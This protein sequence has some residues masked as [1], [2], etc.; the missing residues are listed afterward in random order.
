MLASRWEDMTDSPLPTAFHTG[1]TVREEEPFD[2]PPD[3]GG[4]TWKRV[5]WDGAPCAGKLIWSRGGAPK[6]KDAFFALVGKACVRWSK[7][8]HPYVLQL[9]GMYRYPAED[10]PVL[11]AELMGSDLASLLRTRDKDSLPLG[12]KARLLEQALLGLAHL[13]SHSP[14]LV[15]GS[16]SASKVVV[17]T[18]RWVGKLSECCLRED[19][20]TSV[21]GTVALFH[22]KEEET[23]Y[24]A[25]EAYNEVF[26][27]E[28]DVFG[29]GVLVLHT[30][31]HSLPL[32]APY[33][34]QGEDDVKMF[35]EFEARRHCLEFFSYSEIEQFQ[36][37]IQRCLRY[38]PEDRMNMKTLLSEVQS[39]RKSIVQE[40]EDTPIPQQKQ[41]TQNSDVE[42]LQNE[43][44]IAVHRAISAENQGRKWQKEAAQAKEGTEKAILAMNE[45]KVVMLSAELESAQREEEAR[46]ELKYLLERVEELEKDKASLTAAKEEL[47]GMLREQD[48][49]VSWIECYVV[50][51]ILHFVSAYYGGEKHVHVFC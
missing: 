47:L 51:V 38:S 30:I 37:I 26:T 2:A 48:G 7:L 4:F 28:G 19:G 6:D 8:R 14:P 49:Y 34:Q 32:P 22:S 42:R 17:D 43:L 35:S 24:L 20:S 11:V 36:K 12:V 31:G 45:E 15:H 40:E 1:L 23:A 3:E 16:L 10:L 9:F 29:Y 41:N 46:A 39:I 44:E 13:H 27:V 25:P 50:W 21:G 5:L 33:M 18:K